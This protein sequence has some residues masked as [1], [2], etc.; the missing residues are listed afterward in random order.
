MEY[1][2]D[3]AGNEARA[4]RA[5]TKGDGERRRERRGCLHRGE[6]LAPDVVAV[7]EAEDASDLVVRHQPF[8]FAIERRVELTN[9][10]T[11]GR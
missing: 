3:S 9:K 1:L 8:R 11:K 6:G 10:K 4:V 2:V 5:S 7:R